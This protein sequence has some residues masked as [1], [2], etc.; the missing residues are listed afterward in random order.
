MGFLFLIMPGCAARDT[1][2]SPTPVP[3]APFDAHF[4]DLMVAHD[5]FAVDL[6]REVKR[7][8]RNE[9]FRALANSIAQQY[10]TEGQQMG[11]W[12]KEWYPQIA[13]LAEEKIK[14]RLGASALPA[15]RGDEPLLL[16][17]IKHDTVGVEMM[18]EGQQRT[19][20]SQLKSLLHEA[21][22]REQRELDQFNAI[23]KTAPSS[24]PSP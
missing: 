1:G 18:N 11:S 13:P 6:A 8:T 23:L 5:K 3:P 12:R 15:S 2:V 14:A 19:E 4:L 9:R 22:L 7:T 10:E 24:S 17:L 20:H 21:Q 16:A